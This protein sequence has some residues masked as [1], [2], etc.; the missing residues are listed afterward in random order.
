M[1]LDCALNTV[2]HEVSEVL[3]HDELETFH[4]K[5]YLIAQE[6]CYGLSVFELVFL[7]DACNEILEDRKE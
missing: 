1:D 3:R 5:L 6:C 2:K 7:I 4:T